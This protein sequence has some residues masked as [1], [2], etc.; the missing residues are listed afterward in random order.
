[1]MQCKYCQT[2]VASDSAFCPQ[3]GRSL[4]NTCPRCQAAVRDDARFCTG[5]GMPLDGSTVCAE[6]GEVVP[7]ETPFCP[8][9]GF[10]TICRKHYFDGLT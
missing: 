9:C 5:C 7:N 1:M 10:G 3:C 2:E 6:C 8:Q 4:L